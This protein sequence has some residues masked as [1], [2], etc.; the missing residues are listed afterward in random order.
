MRLKRQTIEVT[1]MKN[2][3][4]DLKKLVG[5]SEIFYTI[6]DANWAF[7]FIHDMVTKLN[8]L[9]PGDGRLAITYRRDREAI[10]LNYCSWLLVRFYKDKHNETCISLPFTESSE[11]DKFISDLP[12]AK[13]NAAR[14]VRLYS[15][16]IVDVQSLPKT[17]EENF[18]DTIEYINKI[19]QNQKRSQYRI[20]NWGQLEQAIFNNEVREDLFMNGFETEMEEAEDGQYFWLTANPSIWDVSRIKNGETVFYTAYNEQGNKRRIFKA[21]QT[22]QPKD[23][24]LFYESTPRKEIVAI[25][26]VVE[27]LHEEEHEGFVDP[28]EGVSFRYIRDVET[29]SWAQIIEVEELEDS[30]PVKNGAQGSL[31]QLTKEEYEAIL[32]LEETEIIEE[33][34]ELPRIDFTS[35]ITIE[36]L[37]FEDQQLIIKQAHTALRSGKNII[38]TGP[39]GTGKSKLAKEICRS[40]GVGYHMTTA[41]SDWST[42]ETIGG[43]RPEA[44]GTLSFKPGLFLSCYKNENTY[45]QKNEWLII[46]EMNR[47][48]IDKAFGSLFSALTGDPITLN[49]L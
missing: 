37:H 46:D 42:Y 11:L 32:A 19:F 2:N 40:Y 45:Q 48:D 35:P 30:S 26:E 36:G 4:N 23:K 8:I 3:S 39:P 13:G 34:E 14:S 43:Y 21:F 15:M 7:D 12:F 17:L 33:S 10:H 9:G 22:A 1:Y 47:A 6:D 31:F 44:D 49:G 38:L 5:E 27:G 41:T 25:G 29:I 16:S 18:E 24:I 20:Y 28:V